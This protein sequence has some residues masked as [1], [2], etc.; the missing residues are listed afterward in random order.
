MCGD[1]ATPNQRKAIRILQWLLVAQR[2]LRRVELET[3]IVL[4]RRMQQLTAS[5]R[6]RGDV[7]SLCNPVLDVGEGSMDLVKFFHFT[8]QES[9]I[10]MF[11]T[12]RPW[13]KA[14]ALQ[15]F[16]YLKD[17]PTY[18]ALELDQAQLS[19]SLS[20]SLYLRSSLDLVDTRMDQHQARTQIVSG[21]H[22][23]HL[24]ANDYLLE[25]L[26]ILANLQEITLAKGGDWAL[27][28]ECLERLVEKHREVSASFPALRMEENGETATHDEV[29]MNL[30]LSNNTKQLF[31]RLLN[32]RRAAFSKPHSTS[33]G[34]QHL[35]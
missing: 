15:F 14:Y 12:A 25:H 13:E 21:L 24:Y 28:L 11:L 4:D 33:Q 31:I 3:G 5:N 29:W 17:R 34:K 9:V 23:L 30:E 10:A 8:A 18:A 2:P 26:R 16:R 7:L 35:F 6:A 20:C 32:F 27:L 1:G 22:D 19:V